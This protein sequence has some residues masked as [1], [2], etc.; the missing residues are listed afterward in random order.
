MEDE[1][2]PSTTTANQAHR[3]RR[4]KKLRDEETNRRR[5]QG[6]GQSRE[7]SE[8]IGSALT[9]AAEGACAQC[10]G[11]GGPVRLHNKQ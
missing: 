2:K 11:I 9:S 7:N 6:G 4:K 5:R 8:L 10:G 3:K 1:I